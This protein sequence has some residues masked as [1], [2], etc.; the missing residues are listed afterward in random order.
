MIRVAC[1]PLC[2]ERRLE[3]I[4]SKRIDARR[5]AVLLDQ[6]DVRLVGR[7]KP[8]DR[9]SCVTPLGHHPVLMDDHDSTEPLAVA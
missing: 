1:S 8:R 9:P 3:G 7:G 2:E 4:V 6:S 5:R